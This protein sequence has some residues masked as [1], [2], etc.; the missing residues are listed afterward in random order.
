MF[1]FSSRVLCFSFPFELSKYLSFHFIFSFSFTNDLNAYYT[2]GLTSY[3][4][5]ESFYYFLNNV[6]PYFNLVRPLHPSEFRLSY[7]LLV[8][9]SHT[10]QDIIVKTSFIFKGPFSRSP[11]LLSFSYTRTHLPFLYFLGKIFCLISSSQPF[12]IG[13]PNID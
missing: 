13:L 9:T 8:P 2:L 4:S 1:L 5:P 10:S 11:L 3:H 6:K 7:S 12:L